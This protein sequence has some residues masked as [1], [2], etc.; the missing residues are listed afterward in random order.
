MGEMHERSDAQLLR[1]YA[2]H[3]D[4]AAFREIVTRHT[5]FVYSAALRQLNSPDLACDIAQSVFADLARKAR[6]VSEKITGD[7]SLAGWL[8]RSTRY[9]ALNQLRDNRRR[10]AHERQAMEQLFTDS[11]PGPDWERIRPLLDEALDGLSDQDREALLLRYFK[12]R[13]FRAV[14]LALG[15]SDDAAQKRV[16]RAVENLREFFAKRG[17]TVGASGL[18]AVI[19]ANAV[20]AAPVGLAASISTALAGTSLVT[21]ATT[22]A[23]QVIVMTTL[24]KT[25]VATA[26]VAVIGAGIYQTREAAKLRGQVQSLRQEQDQQQSFKEQIRQLQRERDSATNRLA[27][28]V[29]ENA[30][31]KRKPGEVLKLRGEVSKLRQENATAALTSALNKITADPATRKLLRDQQKMGMTAIYKELAQRLNLTPEQA[32]KFNDLLADSVMDNVDQITAILRDGKT[33]EE[34]NQVFAAQDAALLE[35]LQELLSPDAVS[36]YKDYSRNLASFL[37]SQQFKPMLTGDDASKQEKARQLYQVMQEETQSILTGAGLPSDFQTV[38]ILNFRNI[39]SEAEGEQNLKMLE[40]IY[41]RVAVRAGS[42][43]SQEELEKFKEFRT[44]AINNNRMALTM[45][46]KMMAPVSK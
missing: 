27:A 35:K 19:S 41:E 21:S 4:E 38:P 1:D 24:Q 23:T 30:N 14:G 11:D 25:L 18:V 44:S 46:R 28:V 20:Q 7:S 36:Q 10:L 5:D 9:A 42:F 39:A 31:L 12:N 37:T 29:T 32:E 40:S 3:G 22:T 15:V 34:M 26:F 2:E 45:N 13:D 6:P 8:H 33:G 43:L 16:R 17:V